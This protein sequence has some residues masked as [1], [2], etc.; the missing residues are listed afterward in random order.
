MTQVKYSL[1]ILIRFHQIFNLGIDHQESLHGF[2][3]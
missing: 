1:V 2:G 3:Q